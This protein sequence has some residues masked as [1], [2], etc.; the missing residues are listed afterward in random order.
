MDNL[1]IQGNDRRVEFAIKHTEI[2]DFDVHFESGSDGARQPNP[3]VS[4]CSAISLYNACLTN[5]TP[6][7]DAN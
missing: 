5:F 2:D 7:L 6:H 3:I 4:P 1:P